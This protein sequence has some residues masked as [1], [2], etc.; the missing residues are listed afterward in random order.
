MLST[1]R[2]LCSCSI[3]NE[4]SSPQ[5]C[6]IPTHP[7]TFQPTFQP[8]LQPTL[9]PTL[10]PTHAPTFVSALTNSP[11]VNPTTN[12]GNIPTMSPTNL[13]S[14]AMDNFLQMS[15]D[16]DTFSLLTTSSAGDP[17]S[18]AFVDAYHTSLNNV[19]G[20]PR[21]EYNY[22]STNAAGTEASGSIRRL[23]SMQD[24]TM[25]IEIVVNLLNYPDYTSLTLFE[26]VRSAADQITADQFST[27][28]NIALAK[29]NITHQVTVVYG[30]ST[31]VDSS[32]TQSPIGVTTSSA[33]ADS[34][35]STDEVIVISCSGGFFI[36]AVLVGY[37]YITKRSQINKV[38][39][40]NTQYVESDKWTNN[41]L[42]VLEQPYKVP[43]SDGELQF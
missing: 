27:N 39:S 33:S 37:W 20:I 23:Q 40:S 19:A 2:N 16:T 14:A 5:S 38:S 26:A 6:P 9:L 3:N 12:T 28:L 31:I 29:K 32:P 13:K 17:L 41:G 8:T 10:P 25:L 11:S 22:V 21:N 36:F 30:S 42:F 4:V 7:P 34:V 43:L 35:L 1:L 18:E 15:M 24:S